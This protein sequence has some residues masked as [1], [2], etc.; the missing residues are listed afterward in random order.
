VEGGDLAF[1]RHALILLSELEPPAV[2]KMF[3]GRSGKAVTALAWKSGLDMEASEIIQK[4]LANVP[5]K[6]LLLGEDGSYPLPE[7]DLEW[8]VAYFAE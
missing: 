7:R 5:S 3:E 8:Y 1:A 2:A 4:K 6:D